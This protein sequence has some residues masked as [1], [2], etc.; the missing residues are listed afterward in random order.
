[1]ERRSA[2]T[3]A[4]C[5][6]IVLLSLLCG[7]PSLAQPA[8]GLVE[9][10]LEEAIAKALERSPQVLE[11][12]GDLSIAQ[13]AQRT[14]VG[15]YFPTLSLSASSAYAS[16]ERY[17]PQTSAVLTGANA[18]YNAG[19]SASWDV[20]TGFRRGAEQRRTGATRELAEAQLVADRAGVTL[21][22]A[23]AFYEASRARELSAVSRARVER[24]QFGLEAA[25]RRLSV[26][27][28][29]RSDVLRAELELNTARQSVLQ[30]EE[31][32]RA[33]AF[34][35]GRLIGSEGP[36]A[37]RAG[38]EPLAVPE[39]GLTAEEILR[40]SP[41]LRSAEAASF[42]S[43]AGVEVARSRYWPSVRL[44]SG[45]DGFGPGQAG[46]GAL[47]T[48][49]SV[50]LGL[51]LPIFDGFVRD[52]ATE[53]ARVQAQVAQAQVE[54]AR[55]LLRSEAERVLGQVK[56]A[57]ARIELAQQAVQASQEDLRVVQDRYKLGVATMLDLLTSQANLVS[58]ENG[59][60]TA[61]FDYQLARAELFAL[62][63]GG[64]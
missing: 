58:A 31:A 13:A 22:A 10:S 51:S 26:G 53:R 11:G 28:A 37:P 64:P 12:Q 16:S 2:K 3:S 56:L 61:R 35:L 24:A 19:L 41:A 7:G 20:F 1:M 47:R 18:S 23:R 45:Y 57:Q 15:A 55:L 48:A 36:A 25:Q 9:V 43:S 17:D 59:L 40:R 4:F 32:F 52:E 30:E 33:A 46:M 34:A 38:P 60:V 44:T 29:T 27:S 54:D 63:G 49:W 14:A 42:V 21:A 39:G 6:G 62:A 50:R 5:R 8:A